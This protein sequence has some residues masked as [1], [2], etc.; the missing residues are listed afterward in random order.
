[1]DTSASSQLN[2]QTFGTSDFAFS[3]VDSREYIDATA[4]ETCPAESVPMPEP[5]MGLQRTADDA[6]ET[7]SAATLEVMDRLKAL[8]HNVTQGNGSSFDEA[9]ASSVQSEQIEDADAS[10]PGEPQAPEPSI[11][12]FPRP[13]GFESNQPINGRPKLGNK[14]LTLAGFALAALI[15][16]G[17]TIAWQTHL[18]SNDAATAT[19]PVAPAPVVA[20]YVGR[21]LE[22]L[23]DDISSLHHRMEELAA[24][25]QQLTAAQQQLDQLAAKQQQLAAKQEQ[26]GQSIS[27]LQALEQARQKATAPVQ[28][29]VAPVS[30][31]SYVPPPPPEPATQPPPP[32]RTA[33]HPI[34]PMPIPP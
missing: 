9:N 25:Q 18:T 32:P 30:P 26:A 24:K 19:A 15:G 13:T 31:R 14:V 16:A 34:P 20:P 33:S 3:T 2:K 6:T 5:D 22:E 10:D 1:M 12:V 4:E 21:Q 11:S 23:A 8:A 27:K 28:T 7:P 17:S 29:R